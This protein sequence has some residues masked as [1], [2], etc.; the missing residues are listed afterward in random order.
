MYDAGNRR[1]MAVDAVRGSV[2]EPQTMV[3]Y[4]Y[5][6]NNPLRYVDPFGLSANE[7]GLRA[8]AEERGAV[9]DW[10]EQTRTA[11][12]T[13]NGETR[14]YDIN[15]YR[16]VNDRIQIDAKEL[17]WLDQSPQENLKETAAPRQIV[18]R[19]ILFGF[20][21]FTNPPRDS[22]VD[23]VTQRGSSGGGTVGFV[24]PRSV[25]ASMD[26]GGLAGRIALARQQT[27]FGM[28]GGLANGLFA[29]RTTITIHFPIPARVP[30]NPVSDISDQSIVL[31]H[32]M[33]SIEHSAVAPRTSG[34]SS[35]TA[36]S[37]TGGTSGSSNNPNVVLINGYQIDLRTVDGKLFG[38]LHD[39]MIAVG[40]E[41]RE[42]PRNRW[43]SVCR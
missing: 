11:S 26:A 24:Q 29:G 37:H 43:G 6:L 33:E 12:I 21:R 17:S 18:P 22:L 30:T 14:Y 10:N 35:S 28:T 40:G 2:A 34:S 31:E 19:S 15:D 42:Q 9:V 25:I 27:I 41:I 39:M 36:S 38:S 23:V 5:V 8:Y 1:F 16:V 32:I 7:V 3:Q 20:Q 4:T 13:H